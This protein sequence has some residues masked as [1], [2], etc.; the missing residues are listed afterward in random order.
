MTLLDLTA[1]NVAIPMVTVAMHNVEP[2]VAGAASG[3]LNTIRQIGTIVGS[4][5]VGAVLQSRLAVAL[6]DEASRRPMALP[7]GVRGGPARR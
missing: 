4:A 6:Q 5:A 7:V 2:R 3:V 1:V